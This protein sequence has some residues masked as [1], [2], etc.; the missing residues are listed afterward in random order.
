[1][2]EDEY[3]LQATT[4]M[5]NL[6][7]YANNTKAVHITTGEKWYTR[8]WNLITNPFTYIFKGKIRY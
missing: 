1:M 6:I 8:I 4:K 2:E 3:E 7:I 5:P